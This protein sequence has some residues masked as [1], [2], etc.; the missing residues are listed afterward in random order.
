[1]V[2]PELVVLRQRPE[3]SRAI[4]NLK[5]LADAH[6]AKAKADAKQYAS[7][8]ANRR[9]SM[10]FDVV[11][12]RRRKY[13]SRVLPTVRRWEDKHSGGSLTALANHAP[14]AK[15]YGLRPAEPGTMQTIARNLLE[16]TA[17]LNADEDLTCR[18]WAESVRGLEHAHDLDPV[19]GAVP[20]IGPALFAYMRMR[21]GADAI[22]P[23][24]RVSRALRAL[25]FT[26]AGE[27]SVIVVARATA[28]EV[29]MNLLELD[30]LLW[31]QNS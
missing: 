20:G 15:T 22:K 16:L 31:N 18:K 25:G 13:T 29:G 27:H 28:S 8:Y 4:G 1:M 30:Q 2:S 23:D 6:G 24:A 14:D 11:A 17:T 3:W 9:G 26:V 21:C 12:S 19:V 10:V 7:V 5:A